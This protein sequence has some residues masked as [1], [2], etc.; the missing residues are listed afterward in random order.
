VMI[1]PVVIGGGKRLFRDDGVLRP[2]RLV[3]HQVT[4][5]GAILA[6]YAAADS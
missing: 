5:A 2:L 1:D 4:T 6:T 3:D